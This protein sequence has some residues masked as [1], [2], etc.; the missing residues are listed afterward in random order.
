MR[1]LTC[2]PSERPMPGP[3]RFCVVIPA[4]N[5][6]G[7]IP[8]VIEAVRKHGVDVVVIDDGSID[9]TASHARDAGAEIVRH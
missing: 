8:P 6:A 5:E 3:S 9:D 1:V 4:F 7:H 2:E